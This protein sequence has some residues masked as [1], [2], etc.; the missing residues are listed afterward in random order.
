MDEGRTGTD[1][2]RTGTDD[3]RTGTDDGR[4]PTDDGR[5]DRRR[6]DPRRQTRSFETGAREPGFA[7]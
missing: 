2:G 1:D 6:L 7:F 3:G 5:T 4:T